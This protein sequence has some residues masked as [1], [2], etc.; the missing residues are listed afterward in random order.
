MSKPRLLDLYAGA[1][2]AACGYVRAGFEVVGVD[3]EPQPHYLASGAA[4]MIQADALDYIRAHGREFDAV[5]ASPPCQAFTRY[6]NVPGHVRPAPDLIAATRAALWACGRPWV[7]E[8]VQ[9][10]PLHFP[11]VL[12]GSMFGLA[13]RRHRHF[14]ASFLIMT[15]PCRHGGQKEKLY[16]GGRSKERGGDCHTP[17]RF[18][19]EIGARDIPLDVQQAAMGIDWT[20]REELSQA[21]PPAYT[22]HIGAQ[23][24]A[25]VLAARIP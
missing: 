19:V 2:G 22:Q 18:T 7:L 5:H 14:E 20:T 10:A 23:L 9:G 17:V 3:R 4:C 24:R 12:C 8:N 15:P 11:A 25:V 13:V 1:G 21:I 16:P 6:R